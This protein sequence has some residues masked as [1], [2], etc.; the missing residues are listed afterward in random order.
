MSS[1]C[2]D[3]AEPSAVMLTYLKTENKSIV[4]SIERAE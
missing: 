1:V 3:K 4:E 2:E